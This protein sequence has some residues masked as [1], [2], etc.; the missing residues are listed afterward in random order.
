MSSNT[1]KLVFQI[2]FIL[3]IVGALNW[4]LYAMDPS[5]DLIAS[6]FPDSG[7]ANNAT[8]RKYIYYAVAAAGLVAGYMWMNYSGDICTGQTNASIKKQQKQ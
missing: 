4:G 1:N 2:S 8:I 6:L 3:I 7:G 5:Q